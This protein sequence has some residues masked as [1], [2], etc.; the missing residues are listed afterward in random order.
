MGKT[1]GLDLGTNSVG[2][3]LVED[4]KQIIA[5]G[6]RIFP[7][8][9]KEDDYVKQGKEVSK[10]VDRR[11][12]RGIRRRRHRYLLRRA[13]LIA[14]LEKHNMMPVLGAV[15]TRKL[16]ELRRTALD[17]KIPLADLGRIL[18]MLNKRRGF[19]SNRKT[20]VSDDAKKEE[21]VVKEAIGKLKRDIEETG[22][23]TVGEYFATLFDATDEQKRWHNSDEPIERIRGRFV[24]RSMYQQEFDLIWAKQSRYYPSILTDDLRHEIRDKVIYFQ[25]PLKSQKGTIGRCRYE[26]SKRCAPKSGFD[27][28]EFRIWQQLGAVRYD[29]G[30]ELNQP[31]TLEQKVLLAEYLA[32]NPKLTRT[33][34]RTILRLPA[35][36]QFNDV[37]DL[38]GNTT[39]AR[40]KEAIG[41][42]TYEAL[43]E[44]AMRELWHI[45]S[46]C[47]DDEKM[48]AIIERKISRR[49]LPALNPEQIE[50]IINTKF[51][52]GYGNLSTKAIRKLL[53]HLRSDMNMYDAAVAAGYGGVGP[54]T[55]KIRELD[56]IPPLKP[57]ELRNPIVQQILTETF[58][59]VNALV[60]EYGKPDMIRVEMARSL[61]KPKKLREEARY[62]AQVKQLQREEYAELLSKHFKR[63]IYANDPEIRKYELWLEMGCK[64]AG[65]NDIES[66]FRNGKIRDAVKYRLW[67]ECDRISPYSGK[68]ISLR[69]LFSAEIEIE[70]I[71]PYSRTMNNEFTNL[72]LCES[73]INRRKGN[74]LPYHFFASLGPRELEKFKERVAQFR[75]I[76]RHRFLMTE[77]PEDFLNSQ[78]TNTSYAAREAMERLETL[79]P[80]VMNDDGTW[81]PRV[82]VMNGQ[83]TSNLRRLWG[84]NSIL[85]NDENPVKNRGDHRHHAVD[86]LVIACTTPRITHDLARYSQFNELS[87]L[88]NEHIK[89]PWRSFRTDA[90]K[91][92]HGIIISLRN[93]K[94]LVSRKPNSIKVKAGK[95]HPDGKLRQTTVSI[96]GRLHEETL[97]GKI[98]QG[99]E[100]VFVHR[101]PI[102]T[103]TD[104]KQL[105]K[106]I[107]KKVREVL[108]KR[109][110]EFGGN[111]KQ[112]FSDLENNP[113]Y[114]Y[115]KTGKRVKINKVRIKASGQ[116]LKLLRETTNT[117]VDTGNNY[118]IAIYEDKA[119]GKRSFETI[120]YFEAVR[121]T[122]SGQKVVRESFEGKPLM[123]SLKQRDIVV[124]YHQHPDEIRW[125]DIDDLRPR[126]YRVRKFDVKGII[127]LDNLYA[128]KL[129][130]KDRNSLFYAV[131]PGTIKVIPS[132]VSIL[133]KLRTD[134]SDR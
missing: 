111:V 18:L 85:S 47:D 58:K 32:E 41:E 71:L 29:L 134:N 113:V 115:S 131:T 83:A 26:P 96:R 14:L 10:N 102:N 23:R 16:Y 19:K 88:S 123:L 86:A 126:L 36:V 49:V 103:F 93:D 65:L 53:P 56:K 122:L 75:G 107:D 99:G 44:D 68:T 84:L 37:F 81:H 78:L 42:N 66:F 27:F 5:S 34:A 77:I 62:K 22:C 43:S 35:S 101:K 112:A 97:Y 54:G 12:A 87:D 20:A 2:W 31:L 74:Q 13:R 133:G 4:G 82:Q 40:L 128:S 17:K 50:N 57:N 7:V 39:A 121:R 130:E 11:I 61:K 63:R 3:C 95:K 15:G 38:L 24:D 28:Q 30:T 132:R 91:V 124:R 55:K 76:K 69:R 59:V 25:R 129:D 64:D 6:V 51:E 116:Q 117:W 92:I 21:G 120:P 119:S 67:K 80:P 52:D 127:Y 79:L 46:F 106:V 72:S 125:D 98:Q 89:A 73:D 9:V 48:Q 110:A 105:E 104:G 8:G 100:D 90:E 118:A 94:R 70:H 45:I 114:M 108:Q 33:K 1:L 109:V 60:R